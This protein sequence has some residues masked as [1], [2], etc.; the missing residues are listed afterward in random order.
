MKIHPRCYPVILL[1][2]FVVFMLIG[3]FVLGFRP[4]HGGEHGFLPVIEA[5]I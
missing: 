4:H 1:A 3:F 5:L 2:A